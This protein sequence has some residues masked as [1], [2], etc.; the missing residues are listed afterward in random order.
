MSATIRLLPAV[1]IGALALL[2]GCATHPG[3][4]SS[5][6]PVA[7][8]QLE[9][10][11]DN[12]V[13]LRMF[14]QQFPKGGDLHNHLSGAVYAEDFIDWAVEDGLCLDLDSLTA[15]PPPCDSSRGQPPVAEHIAQDPFARD[16][17]IDAWSMRNFV[18]GHSAASGHE[19]FF[20]TFFRFGKANSGRKGDML[21]AARWHAADQHVGYLELMT[22]PAMGQARALARG[23]GSTDELGVLHQALRDAGIDSL[24]QQASAQLQQMRTEADTLLGCKGAANMPSPDPACDIEVRFL[25]QVIRTFPSEEVFAQSLLAHLLVQHDPY[26]VGINLVAPEDDHQTLNDY[27]RQMN[28]LGWLAEQLGEVPVALHAGELSLGLVHPRHLRHHIRSAVEIAGAQRIGHGV[29]IAHEYRPEELL[30]AMAEHDIAVEINLTSNAQILGISGKHHP[31]QTYRQYGVPLTLSTDDAGV[32]RGDL[33]H[34]YQRA[35]EAYQLTFADLLELSRN[36]LEYAFIPGES[37]WQAKV[38]GNYHPACADATPPQSPPPTC[39][40][41]LADNPR[42]RL[43]WRHE[44]ALHAFEQQRRELGNRRGW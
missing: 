3:Q 27:H 13:A 24:V 32:S 16:R 38:G 33:S 21:A 39:T 37:L 8:A 15:S 43:Q 11:R 23:L 20:R 12:P 10:L 35:T 44:G 36:A 29:S 42:A 17:L 14:I 26:V 5:P 34:E 19:Q 18:P 4:T 9:Q 22:S 41:F 40:L 31:F 28:Q 6:F 2:S 30:M 25:A 7:N 1:V